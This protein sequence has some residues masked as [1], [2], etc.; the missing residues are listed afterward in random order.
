[1]AF[2]GILIVIATAYFIIKQYEVRMVLFTSGLLMALISLQP[3]VALDAFASRMTTGG[4]IQ[5][6]LS[7]LAFAKVMNLTGCDKHLISLLGKSLTKVR[8]ILIPGAVM[9]TFAINT[10]LPSAA[11]ASAAV[12]AVFIPILMA[13]GIHPAISAS[14]VFAGT[15]GSMLSPGLSHNPFVAELAGVDVMDVI[16][17][18]LPATIITAIIGAISL[19]VVAHVL[20]E[21]KGYEFENS[22]GENLKPSVIKGLVVVVPLA[23]LILGATDLVPSLAEIG[24][25][26]A[27]IIGTI[28]GMA[29]TKTS[30]T[31]VTQTFFDGMGSA[32]SQVMGIIISAAVF[33]AG[34]QAVGVVDL[35][36]ET[37][38][39]SNSIVG[40]AG[41][42]GPFLLAV[43]TGSGD[44]AAFA[45][46]EAVTIHAA[47]FGYEI[48]ELGSAAALA[49]ALGR[50]M[51]PVAAAGIVCAGFAKVNPVE[52]A[53][54][55]VPGMIIAAIVTMFILL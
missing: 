3:N 5:A 35:L 25:P 32:Y 16:S 40:F 36:I 51:S 23:I 47:S 53:K 45:F 31:K 14:A 54:R 22:A 29:V 13:A 43:I 7:V 27:M 26:G 48:I 24:V 4:L 28:L 38:L 18:H 50:T 11:G 42:F 37:M 41:I 6:I 30:P 2:I 20:K 8:P 9:L 19:T 34:L 1:M 46:N 49:G 10:A 39:K 21:N 55:N 15:F 52:L 12:G 17:V 33:V 44:A